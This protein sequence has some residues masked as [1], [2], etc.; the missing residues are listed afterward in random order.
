MIIRI[1]VFFVLSCI[2]IYHLT[3]FISFGRQNGIYRWIASARN[4]DQIFQRFSS[5]FSQNCSADAAE[6]RPNHCGNPARLRIH[7]ISSWHAIH[8]RS[9]SDV[10]PT[11]CNR[12]TTSFISIQ[13]IRIDCLLLSEWGNVL[14]RHFSTINCIVLDNTCASA[15][16]NNAVTILN[17]VQPTFPTT[18]ERSFTLAA[19]AWSLALSWADIRV[20]NFHL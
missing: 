13:F 8:S 16:V 1:S 12:S 11:N 9:T 15:V 17:A 6:T 14:S 3:T 2:F 4:M 18:G 20:C 19:T 7:R 10:G 5:D